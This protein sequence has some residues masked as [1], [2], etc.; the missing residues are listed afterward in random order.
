MS[1]VIV[2]SVSN[3]RN[4]VR[5]GDGQTFVTDEPASVGGEGAAGREGEAHHAA[6]AVAGDGAAP[7]ATRERSVER[8]RVPGSR[9]W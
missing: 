6:Y 4:E 2:T 5:Y 9:R 1:E 3:L 8:S 7:L